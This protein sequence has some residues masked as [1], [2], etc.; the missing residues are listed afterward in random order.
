MEGF[1]I[2][3]PAN[4]VVCRVVVAFVI[5]FLCRKSTP[6]RYFVLCFLFGF[7][8]DVIDGMVARHYHTGSVVVA[9][10]DGVADF[11]LYA[12]SLLYLRKFYG[13]IIKPYYAKLKALVLFQLLAWSICLIKFGHISSW[14][15]YMAKIFGLAIVSSVMAIVLLKRDIFIR[16]LLIVGIIYIIDDIAITLVMPYWRI[17]VMSIFDALKYSCF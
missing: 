17:G 1:L 12:A 8:T 4:F 7:G 14:H 13:V 16:I 5:L 3:F 6:S 15:S 2:L 9:I 11:C 10:L